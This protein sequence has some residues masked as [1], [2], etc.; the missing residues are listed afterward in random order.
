M[1][2]EVRKPVDPRFLTP[3]FGPAAKRGGLGAL[4]GFFE[5]V[6][7]VEAEDPSG[8]VLQMARKAVEEATKPQLKPDA[9]RYLAD[10]N[11]LLG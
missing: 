8:D 9:A 5:A 4:A 1:T 6:V 3:L 7:A 10:K 11:W 2:E